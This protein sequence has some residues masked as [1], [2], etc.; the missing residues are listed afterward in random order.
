MTSGSRRRGNSL[1]LHRSIDPLSI[2]TDNSLFL[3]TRQR[4]YARSHGVARYGLVALL[5]ARPTHMLQSSVYLR[6]L[7]GY[8]AHSSRLA[9]T[10]PRAEL[11]N[12][13]SYKNAQYY[14]GTWQST[15]RSD[16]LST[17]C[18]HASA[19]DNSHAF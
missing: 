7:S 5:A 6:L 11:C 12:A 4:R 1:T 8:H 18:G 17:L 19:S 10:S 9:I 16:K 3:N 13:S 15:L 2:R 14:H